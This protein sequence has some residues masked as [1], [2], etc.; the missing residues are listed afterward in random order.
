MIPNNIS[1]YIN[2]NNIANTINLN[3]RKTNKYLIIF[4]NISSLYLLSSS[5]VPSNHAKLSL[6]CTLF[7][8]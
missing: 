8:K 7:V 4:D 3:N 2:T 6:L 5:G 1:T